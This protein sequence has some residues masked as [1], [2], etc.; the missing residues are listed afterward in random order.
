MISV[1]V[2]G[3]RRIEVKKG[4]NLRELKQKIGIDEDPDVPIVGALYNNRIM[5]LEFI[6]KRDCTVK[7]ITLESEEGMSIYRKSLSVLL[8][9][10]FIDVVRKKATLKIEHSLNKGYFYSYL[11]NVKE[12][13]LPQAR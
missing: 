4:I 7:F 5:G 8:F 3:N 9:A 2:V 12:N 10:V 1:D 6:L 13:S 11:L